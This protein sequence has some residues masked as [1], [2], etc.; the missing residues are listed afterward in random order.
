MEYKFN[1]YWSQNNDLRQIKKTKK[2]IRKRNFF[3]DLWRWI[4]RCKSDKIIKIS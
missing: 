1:K 4:I 3:N 2:I